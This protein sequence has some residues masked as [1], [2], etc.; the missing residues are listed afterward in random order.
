MAIDPTQLQRQVLE[1]LQSQLAEAPPELDA[2]EPNQGAAQFERLMQ[3]PAG[4]GP[5]TPDA[6]A[7]AAP[8]ERPGP[9]AETGGTPSVGDRILANMGG[10][11]VAG[12]SDAG[13][14]DPVGSKPA[15]DVGDP[16]D[17][18]Q[19][20]LEVAEVKAETGFAAA[21]VQKTSQGMDTL[22]KSQ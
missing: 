22:L 16:M 9:V 19:V 11:P 15:I 14:V 10:R 1:R 5:G 13:A 3:E 20:Q 7:A 12:P 6:G 18:V 8:P 21:A 2:P 17:G 4:D